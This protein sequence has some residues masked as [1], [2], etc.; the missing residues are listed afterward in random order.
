MRRGEGYTVNVLLSGGKTD[1]DYLYIFKKILS[2]IASAFNPDFILLSAGFDICIGGPL[3]GMQVTGEG[4]GAL[5]FQLLE[6]AY[7]HS[8]GRIL[9][10]LGG[11]YD[12]R[13]LRDGVKH[14]L[15]QLSRKAEKPNIEGKTALRTESELTPVFETQKK[16]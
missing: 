13:G 3:G 12:L 6:L 2:P 1:E 16:F 9:A 10:A 14:V 11:G 4:F 7:S 15:L 5:V 8:E